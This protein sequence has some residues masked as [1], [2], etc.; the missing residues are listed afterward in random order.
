MVGKKTD[1][2]GEWM[3]VVAAALQCADGRWLMQRRPEGKHHAGLWE[4]PGGKVEPF[5]LPS[6][7]LVRELT[8]ELGISSDCAA[9]E[10]AGF[11][12]TPAHEAGREIVI[13]LYSLTMWD[14]EPAALEGGTIAWFTP[15]EVL[16]LA[17]PPLD[18]ILAAQLFQ[19]H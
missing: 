14:G 4:F 16:T 13:L 7:A 2:A 10:P 6:Q 12:E 3:L 5:E 9:L 19:K 18:A 11:A 17:K 8:E 1:A 15:A